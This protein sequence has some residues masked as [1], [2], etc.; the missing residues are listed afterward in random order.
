MM[1][2]YFHHL[3]VAREVFNQC[4]EMSDPSNGKFEVTF[5]YEFLDDT[6]YLRSWEKGTDKSPGSVIIV[7]SSL[8]CQY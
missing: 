2:L 6:Y 1:H 8:K 7:N 4:T 5:D 3:E